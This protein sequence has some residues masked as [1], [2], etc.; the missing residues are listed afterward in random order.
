MS[1][2]SKID[3]VRDTFSKSLEKLSAGDT[4]VIEKLRHE[5]LGRKGKVADLFSELGSV[6]ESDRPGMGKLLNKLKSE[7]TREI[8]KMKDAGSTGTASPEKIVDLSLP[9]D[10][11]TMGSLHPITKT[12]REVKQIFQSIGF[13]VAY[14]PEIDDDYHNFEALNIPKHHPARDMQD[15]FY[16]TD[17]D[18]LKDSHFQYTDPR[19]GEP[20]TACARDLPR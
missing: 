12:M 8:E 1:L 15:T 16:I 6:P 17:N 13:S 10:E 5:Y 2:A 7:L 9:G 19:Y 4:T 20:G 3:S 18:V 11:V 14:G